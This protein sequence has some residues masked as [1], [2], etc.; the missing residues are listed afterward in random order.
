MRPRVDGLLT[1]RKVGVGRHAGRRVSP[2]RLPVLRATMSAT[3]RLIRAE[4]LRGDGE[5]QGREVAAACL[6]RGPSL[7][8]APPDEKARER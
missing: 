3:R 4:K 8:P 2:S 6:I 5:G 7:R 1:G